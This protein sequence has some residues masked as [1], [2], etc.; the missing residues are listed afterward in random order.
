M[1]GRPAWN[2][3]LIT[4]SSLQLGPVKKAFKS[5][6]ESQT[7]ASKWAYTYYLLMS[8]FLIPG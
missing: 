4:G 8:L 6:H 2:D 3:K 5:R 7:R 1:G